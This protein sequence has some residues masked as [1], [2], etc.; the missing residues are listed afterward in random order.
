MELSDLS[1]IDLGM[2]NELGSLEN[3]LDVSDKTNLLLKSEKAP[4]GYFHGEM[5]T[6]THTKKT[7]SEFL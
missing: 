2:Q 7:A 3:H 5:K 1:Y 4:S 6:Y